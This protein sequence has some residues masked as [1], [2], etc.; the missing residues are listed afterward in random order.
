MQI[1]S[2]ITLLLLVAAPL[3]AQEWK[4]VPITLSTPWTADVS[5]KNAL[6]EY[7]RPQMV[8]Q[9]WSNL[10]GLWDFAIQP[11]EQERP[12]RFTG[13]ILVPFP[14]ESS[15]SGVKQALRPDQRLW[16]RRTFESPK[17]GKQHLLLH[18]G[19]VDWKTDVFVNGNKVGE[20]EGGYD[21]FTFDI[22]PQL[23]RDSRTQELVVAVSDPTDTALHPRG[24]QTLDPKSIWYTAVSGIWQTV[25]L[26]PVPEVYVAKISLVPDLDKKQLRLIATTSG[27]ASFTA[28]ARLKGK[29]VGSA[30]GRNDQA[31]TIPLDRIEPWSPDSPTLYDLEIKFDSGDAIQSYFGMRKIEI[32]KDKAGFNRL[33]LN[34]KPLFQI[35]PLDQGWWPDGLYTAPTDAAIRFDVETL[36]KFGFNMLRKHV[37]VESAR[38]YYWC[39]KLGLMVWQDVPSAMTDAPSTR[40]KRDAPED[41][42]FSTEE[43]AGFDL[44]VKAEIENLRNIPSIVAWV[45]LN[46]GWG[47]HNTNELLKMVKALDS[48]RLVDGP[49]G[50]EDRGF[51]DMKDMHSYPGPAMFPMMPERVSVLGEF[52]GLGYPVE[53]H[54]WW[55]K[56][57]WGYRTYQTLAELQNAYQ[58][59]V[60]KLAPLIQA[61][62]SAAIYTQTSD[63]EGE[64]NGL[65]TYDRKVIKIEPSKVQSLHRSLIDSVQ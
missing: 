60:G 23:K 27:S 32:G 5:V 52:G 16:Y 26:E 31:T 18:F 12:E 45:P 8:R 34:G 2:S 25:W 15:L 63:V 47:Q 7:P 39:D 37:K 44:E 40:V 54:L 30:R 24:K 29:R 19:A 61:G 6:P 55:N 17:L 51:G 50:W 59:V 64:V 3:A 57:N 22:T 10:N 11:K 4:P 58:E 14:L 28:T 56:R 38:Y 41:A 53:G 65:M 62:L 36:K 1:N 46:E 42:T 13:K 49:S 43:A 33:L 20:H 48:T 35:G 21:P 9:R